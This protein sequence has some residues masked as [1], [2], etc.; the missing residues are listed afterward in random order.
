[1]ACC[2]YLLALSKQLNF[3]AWFSYFMVIFLADSCVITVARVKSRLDSLNAI[4][5][6]KP[7]P[8]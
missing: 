3:P 6:G 4:T 1:M 2:P 8:L 5:T 7:A